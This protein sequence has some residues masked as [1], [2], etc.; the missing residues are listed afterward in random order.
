MTKSKQEKREAY[1]AKIEAKRERY[2]ARAIKAQ[3]NSN[4]AHSKALAI[5]SMIPMGQPILVG[6]HSERRHR[7]DIARIDRNMQAAADLNSK[8]EHYANKAE[9]YGAGAAILSD[10]PDA[11]DLLRAKLSE[12]EAERDSY[13]AANKLIA[14]ANRK[15]KKANGGKD[16]E[17]AEAW[18]AIVDSIDLSS[19]P[20]GAQVWRPMILCGFSHYCQERVRYQLVKFGY[21]ITNLGANIRSTAKRLA[22]L[23]SE[24]LQRKEAPAE[25]ITG[26]G[27]ELKECPDDERIRFYFKAKPDSEIRKT[28]KSNGFRWA[29]SVGAW[30]RQLNANGRAAASR[31]AGLLGKAEA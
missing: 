28:L 15:A 29:P 9:N 1:A 25:T 11:I 6:H 8:A 3:E 16:V 5:G 24:E 12:L 13:K 17:G 10:N 19:L 21:N 7:K 2:A 31:V 23:E 20:G 27:F 22:S 4:A 14:A 30:Q 18:I 26:E